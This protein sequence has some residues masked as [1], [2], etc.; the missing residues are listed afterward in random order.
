MMG[1]F[2]RSRSHR[3]RGSTLLDLAGALLVLPTM[4]LVVTL[5]VA[6]E[7]ARQAAC[8]ANLSATGK[9]IAMYSAMSNDQYPFPLLR[10]KGD[11]M[12]AVNDKTV[13]KDREHLFD[14]A[15]GDSAM[16]NVWLLISENLIGKAAFR[17]PSDV[18]WT[19]RETAAEYGW[20]APTQFSYGV[21]FPYDKDA[22]GTESAAKLSDANFN[23]GLVI[24]ADRSPGGSV[25]AQRSPTNH[26]YHG[27][28]IL[29]RD[30][31]VTFY[32]SSADSKCGAKSDDIY[33]NTAGLAGGVPTD[34]KDKELAGTDTSI[35]PPPASQPAS[36]PATNKVD[37][38]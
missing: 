37:A 23:S 16:Q 31:S 38:K 32:K 20:T 35:C 28:A 14:A 17:C 1:F 7:K 13:A 30:S 19:P 15:M 6:R 26:G 18:T 5:G 24:F 22:A 21:H 25:N 27:E 29:K 2:A 4:V 34:P 10:E 33:V 8:M 12:A 11:P 9:A 3:S 36:K